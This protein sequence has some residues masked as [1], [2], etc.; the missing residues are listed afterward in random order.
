MHTH[1][2]H[3]H[4]ILGTLLAVLAVAPLSAYI[5]MTGV[6]DMRASTIRALEGIHEQ[7]TSL[8]LDTRAYR[9]AMEDYENGVLLRKP[10]LRDPT[11]YASYLL[12]RNGRSVHSAATDEDALGLSRRQKA[13]IER[14]LNAM[15]TCP[16][17]LK[18][19]GL[20]VPCKQVMRIRTFAD[21]TSSPVTGLLNPKAYWH[22]QR[23]I[24]PDTLEN[25]INQV[26]NARTYRYRQRSI[27]RTAPESYLPKQQQDDSAVE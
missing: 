10:D 21:P 18:H 9:A 5:A 7:R 26:R 6:S 8:R 24:L 4:R 14:Y 15:G 3:P 13:V 16:T 22:S 19:R 27:T 12:G 17:V 1:I 23:S 25:R 11:T 20:Y 2:P